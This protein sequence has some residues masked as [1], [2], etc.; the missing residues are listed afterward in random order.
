[1][2]IPHKLF[3]IHWD[4]KISFIIYEIPGQTLEAPAPAYRQAGIPA[5]RDRHGA[6]SREGNFILIVPLDPA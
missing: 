3:L 1:L 4:I 6:A 2:D 5:E